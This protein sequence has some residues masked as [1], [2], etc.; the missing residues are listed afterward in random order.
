MYVSEFSQAALQAHARKGEEKEGL[1]VRKV[2]YLAQDA[3]RRD[4]PTL[5]GTIAGDPDLPSGTERF[6]HSHVF[7]VNGTWYL[8]CR[9][10]VAAEVEAEA[11]VLLTSEPIG[12]TVE[13]I[14]NNSHR[15]YSGDVAANRFRKTPPTLEVSSSTPGTPVSV[16]DGLYRTSWTAKADDAEPWIRLT[17][18]RPQRGGRLLL[19]HARPRLKHSGDRRASRVAVILDKKLKLVVE[20]DPHVMTKTEIDLRKERFK[21]LELRILDSIG[22]T[23]GAGVGFSE[24]EL[25]Y[26]R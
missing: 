6:P 17:L 24:I 2:E 21:T 20:V 19:T 7:P 13:S 3:G 9:V 12:V 16:I 22:S 23:A 14:F 1:R 18:R 15:R 4:P 5:I 25:V 8:S 10:H 26:D 11:D